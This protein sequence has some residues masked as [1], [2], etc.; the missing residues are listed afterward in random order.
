MN[1]G[2]TKEEKFLIFLFVQKYYKK[3]F[4]LLLIIPSLLLFVFHKFAFNE[5]LAVGGDF[6]SE[7][8]RIRMFMK[9]LPR[10]TKA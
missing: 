5:I 1:E 4:V 3:L 8:Q 10:S 6:Y 7:T 9:F 2:K